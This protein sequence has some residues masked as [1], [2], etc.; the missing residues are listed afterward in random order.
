[1][2]KLSAP[3]ARRLAIERVRRQ[4]Q[5][6]SWPRLQMMLLVALTGGSG[7]LISF[8]LLHAGLE[9]MAVRYPLALAGA[10]LVFLLLV[11][12]WLRTHAQ[13]WVDGGWG[14]LASDV[15]LGGGSA[16]SPGAPSLPPLRSGGG[17]DFAGGG[18][19]GGFDDLAASSTAVADESLGAPMKA[20]GEVAEAV[21]GGDEVGAVVLVVVLALG[22]ALASLYVV[23]IAP[24]L[25]AEVLVDGALSYALLRHLRG[26]DPQH[27]LSSAVR[28]TVWPFVITA[29]VLCAVGAGFAAYAPGATSIGQ[30]MHHS[31]AR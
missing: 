13:D 6:R 29:A 7:L 15:P 28:R 14:D 17:G 30:V 4:L 2:V 11:W 26:H 25:F 3:V 8:G 27:W 16:P 20:A 22:L 12:L 19:H 18:A 23:Y 21:G 24:V 5:A 1:M 10:Y 9:S 31:R